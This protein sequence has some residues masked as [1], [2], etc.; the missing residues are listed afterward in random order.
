M[1]NNN[2]KKKQLNRKTGKYKQVVHGLERANQ[3]ENICDNGLSFLIG[4]ITTSLSLAVTH[5]PHLICEV[6]ILNLLLPCKLDPY[7]VKCRESIL[8]L[9]WKS[10]VT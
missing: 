6:N 4:E 9:S 3:K 7:G 2:D 5:L 8:F 1:R 10:P